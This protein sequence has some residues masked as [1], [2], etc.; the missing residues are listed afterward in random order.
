MDSLLLLCRVDAFLVRGSGMF[1]NNVAKIEDYDD[2]LY[3]LRPHARIGSIC[4]RPEDASREDQVRRH[5]ADRNKKTPPPT[6]LRLQIRE[7]FLETCNSRGVGGVNVLVNT[8]PAMNISSYESLTS[9][10]GRLRNPPALRWT[11][12][13]PGGQFHNDIDQVIFN[14][15]YCLT[16]VSVVPKFYTE[17]DHSLL[18]ARF[19]F[20]RQGEKAAKFK[21]RS[22]RTTI[23][24][25]LY[26]ALADFW[27]DTVME[28]TREEY[29]R[30][31]YHA[32]SAIVLTK[33]KA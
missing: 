16:D 8:H 25:D 7:V 26:T 3:L 32:I 5:R 21:K 6:T 13:S 28:N 31:V 14:H 2:D 15:K 22:P 10:I 17:S 4:Q 9:R 20:S 12:E 18:R 19:R 23:T 1:K 11:W 27:K 30:F 24:S 29:D 33:P